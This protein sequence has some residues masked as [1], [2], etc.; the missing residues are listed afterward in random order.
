MWIYL[1]IMSEFRHWSSFLRFHFSL[2]SLFGG[3][4][5]PFPLGMNTA[6]QRTDGHGHGHGYGHGHGLG[7]SLTE[8]LPC[9]AHT[10]KRVGSFFAGCRGWL[11]R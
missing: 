5:I 6:A 3:N 10:L 1:V 11:A 9:S 2:F 8:S 7:I 4:P